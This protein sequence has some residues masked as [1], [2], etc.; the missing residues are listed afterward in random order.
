MSGA[1]GH[2][3]LDV[4]AV[5][6]ESGDLGKSGRPGM[7]GA[8]DLRL[9]GKVVGD[10]LHGGF[11]THDLGSRHHGIHQGLVP[12]AAADVVVLLK[13]SP[14]LLPGGRGV[15]GKQSIGGDDESGGAEA[16]LGPAVGDPGLLQGVQ[17]LRSA[18]ALDGGYRT[19]FGHPFHLLGAGAHHLTV[20]EHGAGTAHARAAADLDAGETHAA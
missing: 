2:L 11:A 7:P 16:A 17:V 20:K 18:D 19:E 10:V 5:V 14:D 12:G 15:L 4:V 13:P 3:Q 9:A 1:R 6:G 8:V